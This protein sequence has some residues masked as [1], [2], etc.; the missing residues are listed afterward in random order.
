MLV[1][2][3]LSCRHLCLWS[4]SVKGAGEL[5]QSARNTRAGCRLGDLET[6]RD[7][8]VGELVDDPQLH[9]RLLFSR[10]ATELLRNDRA[11]VGQA[12]QVDDAR[13]LV[14]VDRSELDAEPAHGLLLGDTPANEVAEL[15]TRDRV[16]PA[17]CLLWRG[18]AKARTRPE[19]LSERLGGQVPSD[20]DLERPAGEE[21]EQVLRVLGVERVEARRKRL[22]RSGIRNVHGMN[23]PRAPQSVTQSHRSCTFRPMSPHRLRAPWSPRSSALAVLTAITLLAAPDAA[24]A[25]DT[26]PH[27]DITR[28]ALTA[29]G[30]GATARD[31]VVVNNWFVDL[32]SNSSKVPQSGHADTAVSVLGAFF[33]NDEH[34]SKAVLD[35]ATRMHFDSSL[36]D[37]SNVAKAQAEWDRLQRATTQV[38]GSIK[39]AGGTNK[40]LQLLSTIGTGLHAIQDFYSH[41]NWI[42][43]QGIE[44]VDGPDW[45]KLSFGLTPTWFDVKDTDAQQAERLHR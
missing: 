6:L 16:Q 13:M 11:Q 15:V 21:D 12:G 8:A 41:S 29:E 3:A 14:G 25:F 33:E 23:V 18:A 35:G 27:S 30:F 1:R 31:V 26:G 2:G 9:R 22:T 17:P 32:Y 19:C 36:W 5:P 34:W 24:H 37:V 4:D 20:L 10:Q 39:S 42:E 40:E 28:D 44:G 43:Q 38:L 7:L 45:S